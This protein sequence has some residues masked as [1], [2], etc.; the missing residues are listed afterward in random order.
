MG[1]MTDLHEIAQEIFSN[2]KSQD[3]PMRVYGIPDTELKGEF[4]K[5]YTVKITQRGYDRLKEALKDERSH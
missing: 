2:L 3:V 5:I 1:K 4:E